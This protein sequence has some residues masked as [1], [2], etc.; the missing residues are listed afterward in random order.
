MGSAS[1]AT[2]LIATPGSTQ[3]TPS[4][5]NAGV[6][7]TPGASTGGFVPGS[8]AHQQ[9]YTGSTYDG[10]TVQ[11]TVKKEESK[12]YAGKQEADGN[13]ASRFAAGAGAGMQDGGSRAAG[14]ST[15]LGHAAAGHSGIEASSEAA[16]DLTKKRHLDHHSGADSWH[17]GR[18]HKAARAD[19][20][21][22][23]AGAASAVDLLREESPEW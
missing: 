1:I 20:L 15:Q 11:G 3:A 12:V 17:Q 13:G 8:T 2:P 18:Y 14:H 16:G 22:P 5:A 6:L 7:M 9:Q 21:P 23:A 4:W 10:A 19:P